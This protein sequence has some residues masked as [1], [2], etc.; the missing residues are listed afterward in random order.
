MGAQAAA[1]LS[2]SI[3]I[4]TVSPPGDE[5]PLAEL[6]VRR[7]REAGLSAEVIST[8]RGDS[9]P[10]RAAAW[11]VLPG[12]GKRRRSCCCRTSMWCRPTGPTGRST[13]SPGGLER[14]YVVGRGAL[15]AGAWPW[16]IS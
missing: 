14:G 15:D 9:K 4:R 16:S 6:L 5:R 2:E 12:R 3:Q 10:G 8:P 13:P 11:A 7:L 1:L